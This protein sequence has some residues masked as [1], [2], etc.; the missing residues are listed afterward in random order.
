MKQVCIIHG[1]STFESEQGYL[2]NLN[3]LKIK[4]IRLLYTKRWKNWLG[5]VLS[6][7]EVL[8]PEMPNRAYAKYEEWALFFSKIVPFLKDDTTLVGH[9]L[10]GIFLA[11]YLNEHPELHFEKVAFVAAPFD[12]T[13]SESLASF[14][15]PGNL[16][17]LQE[18]ADSFGIFHSTDDPVVPY[19]EAMKYSS[20]LPSNELF[21][22]EN[23]GHFNQET[24]PELIEFIQK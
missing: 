14:S 4:Y 10:G 22:L 1:G 11:K 6:D 3:T 8:L 20:L 2:D 18:A 16:Q 15:L 9:S 23:R 7:Y 24:F 17:A 5:E 21:L 13:A 19:F 12:D